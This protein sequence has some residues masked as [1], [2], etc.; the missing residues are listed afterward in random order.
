[1]LQRLKK[2]RLH[3]G[4]LTIPK[5]W[6]QL[7]LLKLPKLLI[8]QRSLWNLRRQRQKLRPSRRPRLIPNRKA[9]PKLKLQPSR[10]KI[11]PPGPKP[12]RKQRLMP[13]RLPKT[14]TIRSSLHRH[15]AVLV[16]HPTIRAK[17]AVVSRP[18]RR[19]VTIDVTAIKKP[20]W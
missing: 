5:R 17:Y 7:K 14:P 4:Q 16:A 9:L 10:K 6:I 3:H 11:G 12:A 13:Q 19:T 8:A 1:M 18:L 15:A 20:Q 2:L